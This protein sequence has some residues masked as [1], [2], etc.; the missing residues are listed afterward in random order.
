MGY[1]NQGFIIIAIMLQYKQFLYKRYLNIW[2]VWTKFESYG[3]GV[4]ILLSLSIWI[5]PAFLSTT[6]IIFCLFPVAVS[7]DLVADGLRYFWSKKQ[8][9]YLG[10]STM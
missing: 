1:E 2:N 9:F 5:L 4:C 6:E 8:G 3:N 10:N 7:V